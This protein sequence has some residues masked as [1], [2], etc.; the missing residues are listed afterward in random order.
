VNQQVL[1]S[2]SDVGHAGLAE[3]APAVL[4]EVVPTISKIRLS[5]EQARI[6]DRNEGSTTD[7]VVTALDGARNEEA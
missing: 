7:P 5:F 3:V 1:P 2:V 4:E 6:E